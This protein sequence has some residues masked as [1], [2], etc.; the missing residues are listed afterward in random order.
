MPNSTPCVDKIYRERNRLKNEQNQIQNNI[1]NTINST[2]EQIQKL[3][4]K[5]EVLENKKKTLIIEFNKECNKDNRI[6]GATPPQS[7]RVSSP[8][9]MLKSP[10]TY[11]SPTSKIID[12][13]GKEISDI[14]TKLE[15]DRLMKMLD[16]SM[17]NRI[18]EL[19]K[20]MNSSICCIM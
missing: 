10:S 19:E 8:T 16:A 6:R 14:N 12:R 2:E 20:K 5:I 9:P 1:R 4:N 7:E 15:N 11:S 13:R 18:N 3:K 17:A